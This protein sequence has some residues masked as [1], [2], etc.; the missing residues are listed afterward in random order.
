MDDEN[1]ITMD[2]ALGNTISNACDTKKNKF[3]ISPSKYWCFTYNNYTKDTMDQLVHT[4]KDLKCKYIIGKEI[5]EENKTPHLQGYVEFK[6]KTR[7]MEKIP[8]NK[9]HWEKRKGSEQDNIVYCSKENNYI[10]DGFIIKE[11]LIDPMEGLTPYPYQKLLLDLFENKP[12]NRHVYWFYE[13]T[14]KTGK[15]SFTKHVIMKNPKQNICVGGKAADIKFFINNMEDD[16]KIV[17]FDLCRSNE[18]FVSYESI[19]SIKNGMIFS[20]KFESNCKLFNPPHVICFAN[21]YPNVKKL[22]EDRWKI[23]KITNDKKCIEK[24]VKEVLKATGRPPLPSPP[25]DGGEVVCI[26]D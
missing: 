18:T 10:V 22:S 6:L 24:S 23:F 1:W 12:D 15:S 7:P 5:G 17:F 19:E 11:P 21:C 4:F 26:D 3:R 13:E 25:Y 8:N 2:H 20:T 9:I 16:V 14:G